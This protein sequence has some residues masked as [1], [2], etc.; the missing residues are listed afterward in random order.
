MLVEIYH[1]DSR[2][3]RQC[4]KTISGLVVIAGKENCAN[5]WGLYILRSSSKRRISAAEAAA[6]RDVI[7]T[8][9]AGGGFELSSPHPS[10]IGR[11][12]SSID[13]SRWMS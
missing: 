6:Y 8:G 13:I 2:D 1:C 5:Q 7:V 12:I 3:I 11:A 10:S 9:Q 4:C